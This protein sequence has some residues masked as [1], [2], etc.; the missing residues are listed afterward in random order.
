MRE[1]HQTLIMLLCVPHI[2]KIRVGRRARRRRERPM[3][4]DAHIFVCFITRG[5]YCYDII[6][7]N[8]YIASC[9]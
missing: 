7:V 9:N 2:N 3:W 4:A 5:S 8:W 1:Q 6:S